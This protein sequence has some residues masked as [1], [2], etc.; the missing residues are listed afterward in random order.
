MREIRLPAA[1][2]AVVALALVAPSLVAPV[3]VAVAFHRRC[4]DCDEAGHGRR[5]KTGSTAPSRRALP[6]GAGPDRADARGVIDCPDCPPQSRRRAV[7]PDVLRL[8][9]RRTD[10][11]VRSHSHGRSTSNGLCPGPGR[12]RRHRRLSGRGKPRWP[13]LRPLASCPSPPSRTTWRPR[14]TRSGCSR[15]V[16]WAWSGSAPFPLLAEALDKLGVRR[17]IAARHEYNN[18]AN[19]SSTL[20]HRAAAGG[21]CQD[22]RSPCSTRS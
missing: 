21:H 22:R 3:A 5:S 6:A 15:W 7:P 19:I 4:S 2:P 10:P 11:K 16:S 17:Q 8:E 18:V 1:R 13:G 20:L 9:G 12:T 14:S